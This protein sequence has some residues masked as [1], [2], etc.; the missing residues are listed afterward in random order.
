MILENYPKENH[1]C[2]KSVEH[3]RIGKGTEVA[4][5]QEKYLLQ[6]DNNPLK[7]QPK[8]YIFFINYNHHTVAWESFQIHMGLLFPF[9]RA[10]DL[11]LSLLKI[12]ARSFLLSCTEGVH[13]Q[14]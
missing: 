4:S 1:N 6:Q 3:G 11:L 8:K 2:K 12:R 10:N 14:G 5:K 7:Y 13:T 9:L